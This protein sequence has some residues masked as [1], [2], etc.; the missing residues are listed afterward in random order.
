[1]NLFTDSHS[2]RELL[3]F[4]GL[5]LLYNCNLK[6]VISKLYRLL[7]SIDCTYSKAALTACLKNNFSV[8]LP[9]NFSS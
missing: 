4:G 3:K 1:M 6:I 7:F 5:V 9:T 2:Y 8:N